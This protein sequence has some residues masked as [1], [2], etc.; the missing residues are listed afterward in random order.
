MFRALSLFLSRIFH[1]PLTE[2]L[3]LFKVWIRSIEE[4]KITPLLQHTPT[5]PA[6]IL[7]TTRTAEVAEYAER[8]D[9]L[10]SALLSTSAISNLPTL[11]QRG[12]VHAGRLSFGLSAQSKATNKLFSIL[13]IFSLI[14]SN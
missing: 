4:G 11:L 1:T 7:R 2:K 8:T 12:L 13:V 14:F 3:K 10:L 6:I 5:F 9:S